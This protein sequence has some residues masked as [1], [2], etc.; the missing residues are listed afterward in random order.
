[1][2]TT[3][4]WN[5]HVNTLNFVWKIT[6]ILWLKQL[7][8]QKIV[9]NASTLSQY[10]FWFAV[11]ALFSFP[12]IDYIHQKGMLPAKIDSIADVFSRTRIG[13]FLV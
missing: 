12:N 6:D 3:K 4:Q 10:T 7:S 13:T 8:A 2:G 5:I 11:F 1:M 9:G